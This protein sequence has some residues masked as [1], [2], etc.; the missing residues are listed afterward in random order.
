MRTLVVELNVRAKLKSDL[1]VYNHT[2]ATILVEYA[3]AVSFS[4]NYFPDMV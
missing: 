3:A 2:L 1:A 4:F